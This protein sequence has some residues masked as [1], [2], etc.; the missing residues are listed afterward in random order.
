MAAG[1]A[2]EKLFSLI[3]ENNL[4]YNACWE[5]P[6]I[7]RMALELTPEDRVMVITSA[8]CNAL[9]YA[10]GNPNRIYAVD[11]NSRQNFLLE[12]KIACI[13]HLSFE[14]NYALFGDGYSPRAGEMYCDVLRKELSPEARK[15]WDRK[16]GYFCGALGRPS[17]YFRGTAGLVAYAVKLYMDKVRKMGDYIDEILE[18]PTLEEQRYIYEA[19]LKDRFWSPL[20]RWLV[21]SNSVTFLV[22]VPPNQ[23]DLLNSAY[24]GGL[25]QLIEDCLDYVF[26]ELP[27][28]DNYFWRVYLTGKYSRECCPEYLKPQN[29][30]LL[31]N[32]LVDKIEWF[33][34]SV[35]DFLAQHDGYISRFVLL[36]HMDWLAANQRQ[37]LKREW[38]WVVRRATRPAR[39]L[40]RSAA[41]RV[42]FVDP[43][44]VKM[45]S[46]FVRM[47][48]I[49][50]YQTDRAR[51]LHERDRVH[52]Y[53]SF[54]IGDLFLS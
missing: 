34:G 26:A 27:L 2:T 8:G 30:E 9:D 25:E 54:Y 43:L 16:I 50:S 31:K 21:K 52:M 3:H 46:R 12:F 5:D 19:H 4:V 28:T 13:R 11:M 32:G 33:T 23:K 37:E 10:L 6:R 44:E 15:F 22:G 29:F 35:S 51:E 24:H 20:V 17:F 40:W 53:G 14:D 36:D 47:E 1:S 42:S 41:D 38:Q 49:I 39:V 7:D 18:A 45:G 48:E